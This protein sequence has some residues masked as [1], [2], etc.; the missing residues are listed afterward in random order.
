[1][2]DV[3][4]TFL[5]DQLNAYLRTRTGTSADVAKLSR[6]VNDVGKWSSGP[7]AIGL[8]LVN[9]EEDRVL[10]GQ[11]PETTI[12]DGRHVLVPPPLKLNLTVLFAADFEQY[13]FA[14]KYLSHVLTYFQ[15]HPKFA[16][17]DHPDLDPRIEKLVVELQ[18]LTYEQLNQVWAFIGA[19]QL[20]SA[21]YKVRL[22]A[23]QDQASSIAPAVSKVGVEATR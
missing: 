19:K 14:L 9:V 22:V 16:Q 13:D 20:P 10:K 7:N 5:V 8:A 3:A 12:V 2:L 21:I 1:M 15:A 18:S 17:S 4:L 6:I 23:L 11:I